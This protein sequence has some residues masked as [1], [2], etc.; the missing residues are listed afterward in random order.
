MDVCFWRLLKKTG[1]LASVF[2]KPF[3]NDEPKLFG[4]GTEINLEGLASDGNVVDKYSAG[5]SLDENSALCKAMF[6][7]VERISLAEFN[8]RNFIG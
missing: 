7:A 3:L 2:R 5:T 6:E 8:F 4:F 1:V